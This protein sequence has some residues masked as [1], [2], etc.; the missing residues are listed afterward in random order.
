MRYSEVRRRVAAAA[1]KAYD[2]GLV[3]ATSGSYSQFDREAGLMVI[4]PSGLDYVLMAPEDLVVM[5]LDGQVVEGDLPPSSEWRL[6]AH[7]YRACRDV[8]GV[9]HTHSPY[10]TA[11]ATLDRPIPNLLIELQLFCGGAVNV[12]PFALPGSDALGEGAV[13]TMGDRKAVLLS[14]HGAVA[15][16][17]SV[18]AALKVAFWVEDTARIAHLAMTIGQPRE[19]EEVSK[20][21]PAEY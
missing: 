13:R 16:G 8:G 7:L 19:L 9:A 10:A 6:H 4:T 11:F 15:V 21:P 1:R 3:A 14:H 2:R 20:D 5:G 18:D 17:E 12:A